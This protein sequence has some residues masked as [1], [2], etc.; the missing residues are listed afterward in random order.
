MSDKINANDSGSAER[1]RIRRILSCAGSVLLILLAIV[2]TFLY[3]G[4]RYLLDNWSELSMDELIYH[5]KSTL[6]GTNPDMV[7]DGLLRY[8]LPAALIAAGIIIIY[9]YTRNNKKL[10]RIY[11]VLVLAAVAVTLFM[12]KSELDRKVGL[13]DYIVSHLAYSETDFIAEN[14]VNPTSVELE[15]PSQKRNLIYIYLE[16]AEIT[17]ADKE[18]GGAFEKNIIPEL[19]EL[20]KEN[21]DFSGSDPQLNGGVS[22]SGTTWTAGAMFAQSTGLPLKV[23]IHGNHVKG[24]NFFPGITAIGNILEKEG[25]RQE[26]M[27]GSSAAFGGRLDF[28]QRHGNYE[29]KDYD[30]AVA[31][32][33]IPEDYFVFWGYED[34][35]L[36][37]FAKKELLELAAGD[38]PFNLTLLT[39]DTHFED[40]FRCRLCRDEFGEQY[41]DVFACSSR[42]VSDFV[43]WVQEQDFYENT[44][45]VLCGDHP[46]MDRNFCTDVP[47]EY[48]RK[49]FV[50]FINPVYDDSSFDAAKRREYDTFDMFPTTLASMNVKIPGNRLGL[51][52]NLFSNEPT[53]VEQLGVGTCQTMLNMPSK[54]MDR[55]S[56]IRITKEMLEETKTDVKITTNNGKNGETVFIV[57][58]IGKHFAYPAVESVELELTDKETGEKNTYDAELTVTAPNSLTRYYWSVSVPLGDKTPDDYDVDVYMT[59]GDAKH[60]KMTD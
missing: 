55:M 39:V 52:V 21:E 35:K 8:G 51:G 20:A 47:D 38:R 40:G 5:F 22:L 26:L 6:E 28:Y 31:N 3:F 19:T 46:T 15:F 41:A 10:R 2:T 11:T 4:M 16:S 37:D 23:P 25:Y 49:T 45:I 1:S 32:G 44:S 12:M 58:G 24:D 14:Y 29:I 34:E 56:G 18:N 27:I 30:Y 59:I 53:M 36:F 48:Q 42:Q 43:R 17:Y 60:Y 9:R 50:S 13:S 33:L 54:F 7:R 57:S